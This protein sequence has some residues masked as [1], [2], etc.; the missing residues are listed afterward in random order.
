VSRVPRP[1][2]L[3]VAIAGLALVLAACG[4]TAATPTPSPSPTAAPSAAPS[5][6]PTQ[7][8]SIPAAPPLQLLEV[9]SEGGFINPAASIGSLPTIVVDADGHIYTPGTPSDGSTPLIDPADVRDVGADG[10]ARILAAMKAAGLDKAVSGGV[11]ADAGSTVFTALI[12][13]AP[14]ISRFAAGGGPGPVNHGGGGTG[15]DSGAPG[16]AAFALLTQLTD[17]TVTW[18]AASAPATTFKPTAYRVYT[19]PG[20]PA[21][22]ANGG[23]PIGWPMGT[24]LADFGAAAAANLGVDGLRSGIVSGADAATLATALAAARP[25]TAITSGGKSWTIW[26][27][28][29]LPDELGS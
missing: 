25:S 14:V 17:P 3:V 6:T 26:V 15:G 28:A 1:R 19:A 27:R 9:H 21:D 16:A 24:S 5:G 2:P 20:A 23:S 10:A 11:V 13:G 8:P 18:G 12:D 7:A 29:L 22:A 4:S